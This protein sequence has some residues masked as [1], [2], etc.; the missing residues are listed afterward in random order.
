M[1]YT[2]EMVS[3][4]RRNVQHDP[5]AKDLLRCV[6]EAASP[7]LAKSDE[8][9]WSSVFSASISR[10]W[11]VWSNGH[12]PSCRHDVPMYN[13]IAD[14]F[15]H[16][17]KMQ[18]PHCREL[19]PKNDFA[20]YYRSGLDEHNDFQP[21]RADRSLLFN[22]EHPD[23]KDPLHRFGVDDGEGYVNGDKRW[24]FIGT[25]LIY[26]QWKRVIVAG[27][28][29]LAAAYTLTGDRRYSR[30]AALLLDRV[31]DVYTRFDFA[32][33]GTVYEL[34]GS[35]G[36]VSTWHD[37]CE[38][39][40]EL[41]LAYDQIRDAL[42]DAELLRFLSQKAAQHR[43]AKAKD[44][45]VAVR[46]NIE[47]GILR[48]TLQHKEKVHSNYPR[49]AAALAIIEAV[50]GGESARGKVFDDICSIVDTATAVDGVTGEKGLANYSALVIQSLAVFLGHF[51]RVDPT[52]LP[53]LL[54][55]CPKL[56]QT[57]RFFADM[58]CLD[59]YYPHAGDTGHF[60]LP[61]E[62][63]IGVVFTNDHGV[64]DDGHHFSSYALCHSMYT[65][66]WQMYEAT[67]DAVHAKLIFTG[68][69]KR[70]ENL[71]CDLFHD[72]PES[73]RGELKK[74]I[75]AEGAD[76]AL[77]SVNKEQ[78]AL[79]ILR[80]GAGEHRRALWLDYDSRGSHSHQDAL[81]LG[82]YAKGLDLM[83][84]FGY[85]P[86]HYGGWSG[87]RFTW[88]KE[89]ASHNT[90]LVDGK[91]QIAAVGQST[92]WADGSIVRAMGASVPEAI[93]GEQYAR[94]VFMIDID[95]R[96]FYALDL[97][98]VKGG[99]EHLKLMH[100]H[101]STLNCAGVKLQ[102]SEAAG[103]ATLM[104]NFM[105]DPHPQHGW[106]ADWKINDHFKLAVPG[107]DIHLRYT[108]LTAGGCAMTAEKWISMPSL[109]GYFKN[110]E[111]AW[112]PCAMVRRSSGSPGLQSTFT[113]VFEVYE[114]KRRVRSVKRVG[115]RVNGNRSSDSDAGVSVELE[116]GASDIIAMSSHG[117]A[118]LELSEL[119]I[120][121]RAKAVFVRFGGDGKVIHVAMFS[122]ESLTA[123]GVQLRLKTR[124]EFFEAAVVNGELR[125]L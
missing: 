3:R 43:L 92:L 122:G 47:D 93:G 27:I 54:E 58:W 98:H 26:G 79:A 82:L 13:W 85:P 9:L 38:E 86:V 100:S 116:S 102:T 5:W 34:P 124:T 20:A 101:F 123:P 81:N 39:A 53:K 120:E 57:F 36:Y 61:N 84:D 51:T 88:Y 59:R 11:M 74:V 45:A 77:R 6:I 70:Y 4:A 64:I 107:A 24:R 119:G 56:R 68:N 28:R 94:T 109:E 90:V 8:E 104:R 65:F 41:V 22:T 117:P 108:D 52:L 23:P 18:C 87:V 2:S 30:K 114:G 69:G 48:D 35:A 17:W 118:L 33:Q 91:T 113:G 96:D 103:H 14:P 19:F 89:T 31:A 121:C 73:F 25:Y 7:W 21:S 16:P 32:K 95:A 78:W 1:F 15:K 105:A 66:L 75:D 37:A 99:R 112:I 62:K 12:C 97:F 83:P 72:D 55:R 50:L 71:P 46:E 110:T 63:Y 111:E 125:A 42:D 40:H 76:L 60:A 29:N 67:G 80:S 49:Q 115:L 10:A 44:S 106:S